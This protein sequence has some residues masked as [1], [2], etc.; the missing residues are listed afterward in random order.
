MNSVN[1]VCNVIPCLF[2]GRCLS[3]NDVDRGRD[4]HSKEAK[5]GERKRKDPEPREG[6]L[7]Y[8]PEARKQLSW[9]VD[10]RWKT[11]ELYIFLSKRVSNIQLK[12]G[13]T[14]EC[15]HVKWFSSTTTFNPPHYPWSKYFMPT[16]H[17]KLSSRNS[18]FP[19]AILQKEG[20]ESAAWSSDLEEL[21]PLF[22]NCWPLPSVAH[23]WR[24]IWREGEFQQYLFI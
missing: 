6:L 8:A 9:F 5:A 23:D 24:L 1:V 2:C 16:F 10:K 11:Q 20:L 13:G 19:E 22:H 3:D 4:D 15:L 21:T 17:L 14:N 18:H 7:S 12:Q